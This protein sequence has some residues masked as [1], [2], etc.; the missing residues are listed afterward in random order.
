MYSVGPLCFAAGV[1]K[2][3]N[4]GFAHCLVKADWQ[5]VQNIINLDPFLCIED[6]AVVFAMD[7]AQGVGRVLSSEPNS[8]ERAASLQVPAQSKPAGFTLVV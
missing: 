7:F 1:A 4:Q 6:K 2:P 5:S 3:I 8:I